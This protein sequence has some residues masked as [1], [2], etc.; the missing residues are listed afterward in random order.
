MSHVVVFQA[1]LT[2]ASWWYGS[3]GDQRI[4]IAQRMLDDQYE[5]V[6]ELE[7]PQIGDRAA[8]EMF[9]L[10]NNPEREGERLEKW[11]RRRSISVGDVVQVD[12]VSFLCCSIGWTQ[13]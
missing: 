3:L 12:D 7:L 2:D 5:K 13:L 8:E 6:C 4:A 11:G 1:P 10:T 9:D